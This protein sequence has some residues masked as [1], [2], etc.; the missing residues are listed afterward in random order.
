MAAHYRFRI[1]LFP[2]RFDSQIFFF[3]LACYHG[4]KEREIT[5][6]VT[7]AVIESVCFFS[8]LLVYSRD[9]IFEIVALVPGIFFVKFK[10]G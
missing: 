6:I 8:S 9:R 3:L 2:L 1:G 4:E 10:L 7:I 5:W